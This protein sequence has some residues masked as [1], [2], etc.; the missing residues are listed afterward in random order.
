MSDRKMSFENPRDSLPRAFA[1]D[2]LKPSVPEPQRNYRQSRR[3]LRVRP[4]SHAKRVT[5]KVAD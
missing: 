4:R 2:W 5:T 1:M 3:V